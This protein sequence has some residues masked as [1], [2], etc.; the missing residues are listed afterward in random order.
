MASKRSESEESWTE[1]SKPQVPRIR[2]KAQ[3][4]DE[5][6]QYTAAAKSIQLPDASGYTTT[7]AFEVETKTKTKDSVQYTEPFKVDRWDCGFTVNGAGNVVPWPA[8]SADESFVLPDGDTLIGHWHVSKE[9]SKAGEVPVDVGSHGRFSMIAGLTRWDVDYSPALSSGVSS[10]MPS[11]LVADLQQNEAPTTE[12]LAK[13]SHEHE[14]D[15][16]CDGDL[17]NVNYVP[18][19]N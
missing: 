10:S 5:P 4:P 8:K 9:K 3:A 17:V 11:C 6:W 14:E 13:A 7:L 19:W 12:T 15:N 1:V 2:P 16:S 18:L